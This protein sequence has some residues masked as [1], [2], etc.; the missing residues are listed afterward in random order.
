MTDIFSVNKAE[1]VS[2]FRVY[3]LA[4]VL[5]SRTGGQ[6]PYSAAENFIVKFCPEFEG[7][8]QPQSFQ[9]FPHITQLLI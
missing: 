9:Y 6:V 3:S 8:K 4:M 5:L 7:L 1:N 2:T